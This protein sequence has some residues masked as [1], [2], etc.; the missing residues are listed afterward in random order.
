MLMHYLI[1]NVLVINFS[2]E[3]CKKVDGMFERHDTR[4]QLYPAI[5]SDSFDLAPEQAQCT[6]HIFTKY[7]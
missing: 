7:I 5:M 1:N 4:V 2:Q 6:F 3:K